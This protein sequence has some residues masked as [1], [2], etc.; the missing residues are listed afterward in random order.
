MLRMFNFGLSYNLHLKKDYHAASCTH[1]ISLTQYL[2]ATTEA[3]YRT[4]A[5]GSVR[6][7]TL[8]QYG[9]LSLIQIL[10]T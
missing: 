9:N 7:F 4:S 6:C 5:F 8:R 3:A 1:N 10:V 2:L